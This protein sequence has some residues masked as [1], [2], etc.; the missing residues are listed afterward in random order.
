MKR[1]V[2]LPIPH[3]ERPRG[4]PGEPPALG[5]LTAVPNYA[6]AIAYHPNGMVASVNHQNGTTDT[7]GADP[8]GMRRPASYATTGPTTWSSGAYAYD[9]AGNVLAI[10]GS[11]FTYDLV[12]RLTSGSVSTSRTG[13]GSLKTQSATFDAYGNLTTLTTDGS[14]L[15]TPTST[16]TNRLTAATYDSAGDM[17]AWNGNTSTYDS[18]GMITKIV[19]SGTEYVHLYTA[20]DERVWTYQTGNVSRWTLRDLDGKVLREFQNAAGTWSVQRDYVYRDGQLLAAKTPTTT[21][22]FSLD[23]LGTPRLITK[24]DGELVSFHAYYP[25]GAEATAFNQDAE[26]M[27]FTGHERD[28]GNLESPADDVDYMHARFYQPQLGRMLS[29]DKVLLMSRAMRKPR[30]WNRYSYVLD[31]PIA[32]VDPS[33]DCLVVAGAHRLVDAQ[34]E[35]DALRGAL[36]EVGEAELA[37]KLRAEM[38]EGEVRITSGTEDLSGSDNP[39]ARLIGETI[40]TKQRVSLQ[41]TDRALPDRTGGARTEST[42]GSAIRPEIAIQVNPQQIASTVVSGTTLSGPLAGQVIGLT[43]TLGT[44]L[45]HELG[46]AHGY[47][48]FNLP[49]RC[50]GCTNPDA[51]LYENLHRQLLARPNHP[52]FGVQQRIGH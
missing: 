29:P 38:V 25:F 5:W 52:S 1:P 21:E 30:D 13:T 28:L 41:L 40:N 10:G 47:Y 14:L 32:Y 11:S 2:A 35:L 17:T 19:A 6:T 24:T 44:A 8:N 9:G 15:N 22:H 26:R 23:H 33:G 12:S 18:F 50:G 4:N 39:T 49:R 51:V 20:D 48:A 46:H 45:V 16:S 3:S 36:A 37:N 7:V 42:A 43:F 27:K 31:N 34:D